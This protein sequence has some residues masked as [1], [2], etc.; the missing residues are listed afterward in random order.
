M[1]SLVAKAT[2]VELCY[3]ACPVPLPPTCSTYQ[4]P[5]FEKLAGDF[6][7][8]GIDDIYCMSVNDSFVMNKWAQMCVDGGLNAVKVVPDG[9]G[10]FTEKVG[11]LV[12]KDNLGFESAHGA[13][14]L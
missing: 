6:A 11:M 14:R 1:N 12:D 3:S 4:L 5:G 13:M 9:S 2:L 8:A 10:E 7:A